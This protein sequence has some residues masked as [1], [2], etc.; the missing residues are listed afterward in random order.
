MTRAIAI[1]I[2]AAAL[3][4]AG[5]GKVGVLEQPAPLWGEKAKAD[6][7]AQQKAAA[8]AKAKARQSGQSQPQPLPQTPDSSDI[9]ARP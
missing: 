4:L 6:Y 5:C 7:A 9:H 3:A 1:L 8:E 2:I